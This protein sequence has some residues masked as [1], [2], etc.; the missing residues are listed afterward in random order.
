MWNTASKHIPIDVVCYR[1]MV[2]SFSNAYTSESLCNSHEI[3]DI[4]R[5]RIPIACFIDVHVCVTVFYLKLYAIASKC[6][7]LAAN[8]SLLMFV[9]KDVWVI[10]F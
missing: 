5:K 6:G 2:G 8:I 9:V 3:W 1:C 4:G 10:V 7:I